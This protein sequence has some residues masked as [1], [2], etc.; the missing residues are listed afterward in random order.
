MNKPGYSRRNFVSMGSVLA[1]SAFATTVS[2][3]ATGNAGGKS[4]GMLNVVDFGA[5]GDGINDDTQAVQSA[6]DKAALSNGAVF[7]PEGNY[8]CSELKVPK[9]IGLYGLPAWSY[10]KGM[11][12]ILTFKAGGGKCLINLTGAFG[13]Y[14]SGLCLNG[15]HSE[16]EIHGVLVDKPDYG[17]Q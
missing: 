17:K 10:G 8:L 6:M 5:K 14:L 9:G 1:A 15:K 13:A 12:T 2:G 11:G 4:K 7:I 16:G 3:Q